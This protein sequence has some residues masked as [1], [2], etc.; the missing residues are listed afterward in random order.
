[1][2]KRPLEHD[3]SA[4]TGSER[5]RMN[6]EEIEQ[7]YAGLARAELNQEPGREKLKWWSEIAPG[8][9]RFQCSF[10]RPSIEAV[11]EVVRRLSGDNGESA[12]K[13]LSGDG[14]ESEAGLSG[15][16]NLE[17]QYLWDAAD[18]ETVVH[19]ISMD[20]ED[21]LGR[22]PSMEELAAGLSIYSSN[23]NP[24]PKQT[25]CQERLERIVQRTSKHNS[26][27]PWSKSA[28]TVNRTVISSAVDDDEDQP[29][30]R[31]SSFGKPVDDSAQLAWLRES[32]SA[33]IDALQNI[34]GQRKA[35]VSQ[36]WSPWTQARSQVEPKTTIKAQDE[37]G[38][39]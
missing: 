26:E 8:E 17:Y 7:F 28:R 18:L 14:S 34:R 35:N 15:M 16:P 36:A 27:T 10:K 22:R 38:M 25:W 37:S 1:M 33:A 4:C 3:M 13:R 6:R 30:R 5:R 9:L 24:D 31:R 21:A 11:D 12:G 2:T 29:E 20:M 19:R 23:A 32:S 39:K